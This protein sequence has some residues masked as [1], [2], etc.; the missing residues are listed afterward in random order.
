MPI[1]I[2][3]PYSRER[4]H[5]LRNYTRRM[6]VLEHLYKRRDAVKDLILSL[7][8]YQQCRKV[9]AAECVDFSVD[10]KCS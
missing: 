10:R 3:A 8:G 2:P 4:I 6:Q 5:R 1:A 7:E 9:C